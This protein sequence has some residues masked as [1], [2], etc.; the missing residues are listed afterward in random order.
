[1]QEFFIAE[2][3]GDRRRYP[4]PWQK[5]TYPSTSSNLYFGSITMGPNFMIC[6]NKGKRSLPKRAPK[7]GRKGKGLGSVWFSWLIR[8][9]AHITSL[10]ED[11]NGTSKKHQT[12]REIKV[13]LNWFG[14][15]FFGTCVHPWEGKV[16]EF[17]SFPWSLHPWSLGEGKAKCTLSYWSK[18]AG[19]SWHM[20]P[21]LSWDFESISSG[22]FVFSVV[23]TEPYF[24]CQKPK[25]LFGKQPKYVPKS[26][27]CDFIS[28]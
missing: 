15:C 2:G 12:H 27:C 21:R 14:A 8:L 25:A 6:W 19:L 10:K 9:A 4:T 5:L 17:R 11:T 24:S 16:E 7:G 1:M 18:K 22:L 28:C 13:T 20:Y 23:I 26:V 3:N